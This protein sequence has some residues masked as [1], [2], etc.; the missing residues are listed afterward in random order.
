[1]KLASGLLQDTTGEEYSRADAGASIG[2]AI[3]FVDEMRFNH[4]VKS[5][6]ARLE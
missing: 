5:I 4:E 2:R 1:M 6:P 3:G